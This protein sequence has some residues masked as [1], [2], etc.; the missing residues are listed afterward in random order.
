MDDEDKVSG[1]S[2]YAG[3]LDS[4]MALVS[5]NRDIEEVIMIDL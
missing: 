3:D 5:A 4:V 1:V 2:V